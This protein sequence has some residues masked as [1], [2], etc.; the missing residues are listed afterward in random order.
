V[1]ESYIAVQAL[2]GA[3]RDA[4]RVAL[5]PDAARVSIGAPRT[6][7][8]A[9]SCLKWKPNASHNLDVTLTDGS[10]IDQ[11]CPSVDVVSR[12]KSDG[13]T[14]VFPSASV[15]GAAWVGSAGVQVKLDG[16][17][18][19]PLPPT[20]LMLQLVEKSGGIW[21][22]NLVPFP[23]QN[24]VMRGLFNLARPAPWAHDD[25]GRLDLDEVRELML[26]WGGYGGQRGQ[27]YG[28]SIESIDLFGSNAAAR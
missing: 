14:W 8:N 28:Y 18:G 19:V 21:L 12:V 11:P 5:V 6:V 22:V 23:G 26:G 15:Q 25:N 27:R 13:E 4:A 17:N 2:M 20:P 16:L 24:G 7:S 10:N 1:G 9:G 3:Q